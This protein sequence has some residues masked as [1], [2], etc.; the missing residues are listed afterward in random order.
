MN[1]SIRQRLSAAALS[2][3]MTLAMLA[4]V[5]GLANADAHVSSTW[6]Q[7]AGAQRT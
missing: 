1:T 4:G 5:E 6:S 2:A 3:F 7:L